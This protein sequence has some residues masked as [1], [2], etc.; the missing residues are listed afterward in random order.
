MGQV[1]VVPADCDA[2]S[3]SLACR[4]P[5]G[6]FGLL[7][8]LPLFPRHGGWLSMCTDESLFVMDSIPAILPLPIPYPAVGCICRAV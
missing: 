2:L 5:I 1:V 8:F 6:V 4:V 7:F 3:H